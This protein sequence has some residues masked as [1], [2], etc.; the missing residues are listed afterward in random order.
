MLSLD[1]V[2]KNLLFFGEI[3]SVVEIAIPLVI[4]VPLITL[5]LQNSSSIKHEAQFWESFQVT[6]DWRDID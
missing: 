6:G 2:S 3:W 4:S 1:C 5:V